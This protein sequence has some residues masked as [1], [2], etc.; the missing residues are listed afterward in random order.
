LG[1]LAAQ[2][3]EPL[4]KSRLAAWHASRLH[5]SPHSA[6]LSFANRQIGRTQAMH[7]D[8]KID[9]TICA[10]DLISTSLKPGICRFL[11]EFT[12]NTAW[13]VSIIAQNPVLFFLL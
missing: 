4:I 2:L 7:S 8:E 10:P 6:Q 1:S 5:F 12:I 13:L 9:R 3:K 11:S